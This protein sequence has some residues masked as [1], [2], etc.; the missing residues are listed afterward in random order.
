MEANKIVP[1]MI[2]G[3]LVGFTIG[4]G[5]ILAKRLFDKKEPVVVVNEP[6]APQPTTMRSDRTMQEFT[7]FNAQGTPIEDHRVN[8]IFNAPSIP[9]SRTQNFDFTTGSLF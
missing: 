9:R 3:V 5:F 1:A 6:V 2:N 8:E 7:G 4:V